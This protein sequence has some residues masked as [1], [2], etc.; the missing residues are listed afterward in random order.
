MPTPKA[1]PKKRKKQPSKPLSD[2]ERE[3]LKKRV[4]E[5]QETA[6]NILLGLA[7]VAADMLDELEKCD[8]PLDDF[9]SDVS[10]LREFHSNI[11]DAD[12]ALTNLLI[13][14]SL[15]CSIDIPNPCDLL[16]TDK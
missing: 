9:I 4:S 15:P 8:S 2:T 3:S 1:I 10:D 6:R 11:L 5:W 13:R 16:R 14:T 7:E 12:A